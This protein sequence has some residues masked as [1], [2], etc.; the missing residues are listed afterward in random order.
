MLPIKCQL[1]VAIAPTME[2]KAGLK[3]K[4]S[5]RGVNLGGQPHWRWLITAKKCLERWWHRRKPT[6]KVA[7]LV[8]IEAVLVVVTGMDR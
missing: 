5:T 3:W 2:V 6:N 8:A 4:I 7:S 1:L